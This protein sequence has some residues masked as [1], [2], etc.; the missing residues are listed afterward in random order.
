MKYWKGIL[1]AWCLLV[2]FNINAQEQFATADLIQLSPPRVVIDSILF[3]QSAT[4]EIKLD[5]PGVVIRYELNGKEVLE[6]SPQYQKKLIITTSVQL[7]VKAFHSDFQPSKTVSLWTVKVKRLPKGTIIDVQPAANS[8]YTGTG[9]SGLI[10]LKKGSNNYGSDK[11]WLGFKDSTVQLIL[12]FPT[13]L[14][15]EAVQLS[16]LENNGGW[17]FLP[18]RIEVE[19]DGKVIG[20]QFWS[21][22]QSAEETTSKLLTVMVQSQAVKQL[23]IKIVNH[24]TIPEWHPGKGELPWLFLDEILIDYE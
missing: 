21:V 23:T 16:I 15:V 10:D 5:Y 13:Q 14:K 7:N 3:K 8:R 17:I 18:E 1:C 20:S 19:A 24:P 12:Q 6:T 9:P 11:R 22:P 2:S 4:V